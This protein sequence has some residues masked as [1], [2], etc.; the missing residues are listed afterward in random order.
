MFKKDQTI[1]TTEN[2]FCNSHDIVRVFKPYQ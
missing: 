2:Y 1:E